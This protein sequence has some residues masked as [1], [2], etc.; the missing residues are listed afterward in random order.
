[1]LFVMVATSTVAEDQTNAPQ[2]L[3]SDRL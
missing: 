2:I 1:M 3:V